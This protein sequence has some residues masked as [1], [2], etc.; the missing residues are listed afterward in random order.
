MPFA[1]YFLLSTQQRIYFVAVDAIICLLCL[2]YSLIDNYFRST[3]CPAL[4][5]IV[6]LI[7][8]VWLFYLVKK[9]KREEKERDKFVDQVEEF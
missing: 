4:A 2:I 9:L 3:I 8:I 6:E 1:Y 7:L 5:F